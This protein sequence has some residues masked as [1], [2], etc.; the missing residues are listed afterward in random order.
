MLKRWSLPI[1]LVYLI[2]LTIG[3]LGNV[4]GIPKLGFSFDDKI[5]HFS[6]YAVLTL[7]LYNFIRTTNISR[8]IMISAVVSVVYGIIIEA[9]QSLLTDFRTPDYYDVIANTIGVLVAALFLM[10]FK[11][12]LKLK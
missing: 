4:G 2:V 10:K 5:Y 7:L 8:K 12:K 1:V 6:A 9:L 11:D 3:S